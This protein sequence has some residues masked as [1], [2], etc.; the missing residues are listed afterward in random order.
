MPVENNEN[1]DTLIELDEEDES[2]QEDDD[3]DIDKAKRQ[4]TATRA[5]EAMRQL[6]EGTFLAMPLILSS[7]MRTGNRL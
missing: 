4:Q 2:I 3:E 5:A 6:L 1:D 7:N